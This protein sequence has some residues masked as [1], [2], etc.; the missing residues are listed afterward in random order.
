MGV[1]GTFIACIRSQR[2]PDEISAA[3]ALIVYIAYSY[4]VAHKSLEGLVRYFCPYVHI[5]CL[6]LLCDYVQRYEDTVSVDLR[7]IN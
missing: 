6:Y 2:E 1:A 5:L 4:V 3:S 7:Y